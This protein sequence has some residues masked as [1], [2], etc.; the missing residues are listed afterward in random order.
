M[1]ERFDILKTMPSSFARGDINRFL[2]AFACFYFT[3]GRGRPEKLIN[4]LWFVHR[5]RIIGFFAVE[6]IV[7]NVGQLPQ[8]RTMDDTAD[9]KWQIK[10]DAWVAVCPP[11][12]VRLP[13]RIFHEGFRGWR[14][15]DL[16]SYSASPGA[17]VR[18]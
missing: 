8:L 2:R 11:P 18:I 17:K 16:A 5:G 13:E 6:E 9:S 14:Y 7:Q 10:P 4:R 12:F 1:A 15:F 3:L